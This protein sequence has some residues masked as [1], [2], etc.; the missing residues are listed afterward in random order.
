MFSAELCYFPVQKTHTHTRTRTHTH[1]HTRTHACTHARTHAH[2]GT[3]PHE[4][5]DYAKL[6]LHSLTRAA[7][8]MAEDS[9]FPRVQ[10]RQKKVGAVPD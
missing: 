3:R 4:H 2:R 7:T 10:K 1:T 8:E 5:S 6:N 9:I